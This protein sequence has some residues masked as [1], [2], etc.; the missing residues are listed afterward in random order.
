V[1]TLERKGCVACHSTDGSKRVGPSFRGLYWSHRKVVTDGA[2]RQIVA[3]EEYVERSLRDPDAD[4]VVGFPRGNMPRFELSAEE[5]A[6]V[7]SELK[8]LS[9]TVVPPKQPSMAPFAASVVWF[10]GMH[11]LLSSIPVRTKLVA[12]MKQ[13]G[14]AGLYS[15]VV[16]IGLVGIVWHFRSVPYIELWAP[17]R[18]TRWVPILVMPIALLFMVLGFSTPGPTSVRQEER[19][20]DAS[21]AKG[22]QA[23]TRHPAL[24]G[25]AL[26]AISHLATNGELHV[27]ILTVG[28]LTLAIAGMFHIDARRRHDLGDAWDAYAERTSIL[29]FA[30]IARGKAKLAFKDIGIVRL[31]ITAVIY[32]GILHTHALV[33]GAS[34]FP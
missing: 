7:Q 20:K 30:A 11:F 13:G 3:N 15:L 29:P 23:V 1:G 4:V 10:V 27:V 28:I 14:F 5:L 22:I 33:I 17:P 9:E 2:E 34:P 31:V 25:F 24:W 8:N 19:A 6:S 32:V 18:V 12:K 21:P 26:W 16:A